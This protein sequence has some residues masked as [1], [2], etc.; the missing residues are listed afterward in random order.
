ML[1]QV[2]NTGSSSIKFALFQHQPK[3]KLISGILEKIGEVPSVLKFQTSLSLA[4][5]IDFPE[6][7]ADHKTGIRHILEFLEDEGKAWA[8]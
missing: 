5:R 4:K 6:G 1:I 3:S 2:F 8:P 7:C